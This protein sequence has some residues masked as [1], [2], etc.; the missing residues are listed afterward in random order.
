MAPTRELLASYRAKEIN[1]ADFSQSYREL[2]RS[3]GILENLTIGTFDNAVLLC[4]ENEPG[5]CHRTLM[6]NMIKEKLP[7]F[8]I[9]N[10][11]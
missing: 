3:R 6:A 5:K 10:L 2:I 8:E 7:S 11:I 1:W 4:S 9:T